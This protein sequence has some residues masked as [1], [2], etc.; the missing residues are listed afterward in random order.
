MLRIMLNQDIGRQQMAPNSNA[1]TI[2]GIGSDRA[3]LHV[4]IWNH[5]LSGLL[6][7]HYILSLTSDRLRIYDQST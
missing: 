5:E 4:T 1:R 6:V 3:C 7:N 2:L